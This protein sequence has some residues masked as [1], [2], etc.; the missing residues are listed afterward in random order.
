MCYSQISRD[1]LPYGLVGN[2]CR[3][4][5]STNDIVFVS[6]CVSLLKEEEILVSYRQSNVNRGKL[7]N[8]SQKAKLTY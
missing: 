5:F 6:V 7:H 2:S 3:L 1:L 8:V 4:M